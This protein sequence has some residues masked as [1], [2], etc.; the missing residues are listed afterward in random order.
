MVDRYAGD[1]SA[2][3]VSPGDWSYSRDTRGSSARFAIG[4]ASAQASI[5]CTAGQ[6]TLARAG[7]IPADI[8]AMLNIR[9]SFA[10]RQL[11][12]RIDMAGRMLTATLPA[13]DPLWDQLI[14]SRGRF[15]IEATRQAPIIVPTRPEVARVIEDCRT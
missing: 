14:Y 2:A 4:T 9:S 7:V 13:R 10:E 3:D 11:P 5:S 8:A 15:V 1:W 12:I 6:I